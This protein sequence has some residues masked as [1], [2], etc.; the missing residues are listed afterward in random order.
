MVWS[1]YRCGGAVRETDPASTSD[2]AVSTRC[3]IRGCRAICRQG[4]LYIRPLVRLLP[5]SLTCFT[6][7]HT[8]LAKELKAQAYW[9]HPGSAHATN[10]QLLHARLLYPRTGMGQ[11]GDWYNSCRRP[12]GTVWPFYSCI[13]TNCLYMGAQASV[14][15]GVWKL[16]VCPKLTFITK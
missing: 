8:L 10:V 7:A 6:G 12:Q 14:I 11:K 4:P 16:T 13:R 9:A 15:V 3:R 5:F 2:E 1:R